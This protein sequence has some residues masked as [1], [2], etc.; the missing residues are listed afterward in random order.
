MKKIL[1]YLFKPISNDYQNVHVINISERIRKGGNTVLL[2]HRTDFYILLIVTQ[3]KGVHVIDF[4]EI[5]LKTNDILIIS[6]DQVHYFRPE[7]NY[8]GLL[9]AFTET[10]YA[11]S[12]YDKDFLGSA[13]IFNPLRG[14]PL[15]K[16]A[17]GEIAFF[18]ESLNSLNTELN[19]FYDNFQTPILHNHL[20]NL[21]YYAERSFIQSSDSN[22]LLSKDCLYT[23]AFKKLVRQKFIE[24][25]TV[26]EYANELLISERRLQKATKIAL[27]KSPKAYI[28]D[29]IVLESKRLLVHENATIKEISYR[30]GFEEP[31]NFT[32]FF[33]KQTGHSPKVL[34]E[35]YEKS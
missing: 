29:H 34:K 6:P 33:T 12:A 31:T 26:R 5:E 2:P 28:N 22:I 11:Q 30:L 35:K 16:P 8:D 20:S 10:F 15:L 17:V 4:E 19:K 23:L 1:T 14:T 18:K 27:G 21:L 13:H 32:K 9:I 7:K 25:I 3:G 24:H